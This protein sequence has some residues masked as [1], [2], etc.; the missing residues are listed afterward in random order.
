MTDTQ[1]SNARRINVFVSPEAKRMLHELGQQW[2]PNLKRPD[3]SALDRI[4][5]TTY[6]R[7]LHQ[8]QPAK[9]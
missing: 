7:E 4:I 9:S 8:R 2:F 3:G 1:A 5:R 6:E